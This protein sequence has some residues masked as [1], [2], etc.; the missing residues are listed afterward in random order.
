MF[1]SL[2]KDP[3]R[4]VLESLA[5]EGYRSGTISEGIVRQMLGFGT[6]LEVHEF[7]A[8]HGVDLNYRMADWIEDRETA[9]RNASDGAALP[10]S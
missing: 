8:A 9:D 5:L 10:R 1:S 3:S 4:A 6:R 7:L 2:G